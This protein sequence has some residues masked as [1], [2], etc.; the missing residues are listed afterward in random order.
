[1]SL[2]WQF[3]HR[4]S[5][6]VNHSFTLWVQSSNFEGFHMIKSTGAVLLISSAFLALPV[7]AAE[8]S[9]WM[10]STDQSPFQLDPVTKVA[11][12]FAADPLQTGSL[13]ALPC[14]SVGC[15]LPPE[16]AKQQNTRDGASQ[17]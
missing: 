2:L 14:K 7:A 17:N 12:T 3:R 6:S 4:W 10:G 13:S 16:A 15:A 8:L 1:M 9:P 11:V 5:T